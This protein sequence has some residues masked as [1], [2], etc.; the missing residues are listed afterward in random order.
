[1]TAVVKHIAEK[2]P[3]TVEPELGLMIYGS[4]ARGEAGSSSDLDVL[5]LVH[6]PR[7][8]E[9]H[10]RA[11]VSS[12][13]MRQLSELGQEGSLFL[14]HLITD[15]VIFWDPH[16]QLSRLKEIYKKPKDYSTLFA[17]L[18]SVISLINVAEQVYVLAPDRFDRLLT[19]AAR[20]YVYARAA[21]VV[22]CFSLP[23]LV[24]RGFG[25]AELIITLRSGGAGFRGYHRLCCELATELG[26]SPHR[27]HDSLESAIRSADLSSNMV[28]RFVSDLS[29]SAGSS[30]TGYAWLGE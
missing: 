27:A 8:L 1:M 11:Q 23:Q 3:L 13:T 22:P 14:L 15:G 26:D 9:Q 12:Y 2:I 20:S 30:G 18:R 10:G 4:E 29:R 6:A 7:R 16:G 25:M 28:R 24:G 21:E 5:R 19:F 17:E